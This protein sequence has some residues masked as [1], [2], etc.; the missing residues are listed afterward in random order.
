MDS[1]GDRM[2]E[3]EAAFK[4]VLPC[5]MPV[6]LRLD[7]RAFSKWVKVIGAQRPFDNQLM[8]VMARTAKHL[9]AS[10]QGAVFAYTQSDEISILIHNYKKLTSQPWFANEV[11]KI[12]SISAA[13]ASSFRTI[14]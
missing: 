12:T 11:Q 4:T 8:D 1:L 10:I 5:R 2:K 14:E 3:Y 13:Q 6:L 7:G 9:C